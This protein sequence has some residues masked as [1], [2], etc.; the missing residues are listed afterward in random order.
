M[1]EAAYKRR[2]GG[3]FV[4]VSTT[5]WATAVNS[6]NL[7]TTKDRGNLVHTYQSQ[8]ELPTN[9]KVSTDQ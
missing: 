8:L 1:V 3:Q 6:V 5:L 7:F 4:C 2:M 9:A